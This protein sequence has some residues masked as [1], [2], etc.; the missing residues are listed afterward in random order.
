MCIRIVFGYE[1]VCAEFSGMCVCSIFACGYVY[2][3]FAC[4]SVCVVFTRVCM[5]VCV[6]VCA[7]VVFICDHVCV[8]RMEQRE[9]VER[10]NKKKEICK[11]YFGNLSLNRK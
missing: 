9:S 8:E 2:V 7:Y 1:Y 6:C 3:L 5:C 11:T 4:K 10:N